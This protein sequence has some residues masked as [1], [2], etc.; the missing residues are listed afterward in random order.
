VDFLLELG[1]KRFKVASRTLRD[2]EELVHYIIAKELPVIV[3]T[4]FVR[5]NL[6]WAP[7]NNLT[8]MHCVSQYPT[9]AK[10]ASLKRLLAIG[11]PMREHHCGYSDHTVGITAPIAAVALGATVIEKH[12]RLDPGNPEHPDYCCSLDPDEFA[13]MVR[14]I[15]EL[16]LMLA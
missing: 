13:E 11:F 1:V 3:S 6:R 14:R 4:G 5:F 2:D 8:V 15:R 7:N 16:E 10:N 9:S 12:I